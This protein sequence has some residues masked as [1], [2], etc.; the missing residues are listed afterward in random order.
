MKKII[1]ILLGMVLLISS[2]CKEK[3]QQEVILPLTDE[4]IAK[5]IE[6]G[7]KNASLS[8]TEFTHD[9]TVNLGYDQGKGTATIITP[10]LRVALLSKQGVVVGGKTDEQVI[11]MALEE[12]KDYINFELLLF[13]GSPRF[14][15]TA[16]FLLKYGDKEVLPSYC[17]MPSY[18]EIARDYTQTAKCR[19]KF[20]KEGI[21]EDAKVILVVSFKPD[22]D[23]KDIS[24]CEFVFE[25][26]KYL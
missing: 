17:F 2:G 21:P 15:R 20:K 4:Q 22:E 26:S 16:K 24:V 13:G 8:F 10:F 14:A 5:A 25:L 19:V 18:S 11:K 6:Y 7:V 3:K 12:E 1:G 23:I 9:W